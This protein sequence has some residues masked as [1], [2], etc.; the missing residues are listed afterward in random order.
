MT[1]H[2]STLD[3][4]FGAL[5]GRAL[6]ARVEHEPPAD[7]TGLLRVQAGARRRRRTNRSLV[8]AAGAAVVLVLA[9]VAA[10]D[11][12][13]RPAPSAPTDAP[14]R[15]PLLPAYA[16]FTDDAGSPQLPETMVGGAPGQPFATEIP[17][18][19]VWTKGAAVL[20]VRTYASD[21]LTA[22]GA[23][24]WSGWGPTRP[25]FAAGL[26]RCWRSLATSSRYGCPASQRG[27]SPLTATPW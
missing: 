7:T 13:D 10:V 18:V 15:A 25:R 26:E 16:L 5:V 8:A 21:V 12:L 4:E 11:R 14:A 6:R 1:P 22:V 9:G 3:D 23:E 20:V 19:D 27:P 17:A 2:G 24:P